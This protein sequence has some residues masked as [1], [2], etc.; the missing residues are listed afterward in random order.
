MDSGAEAKWRYSIDSRKVNRCTHSE[1]GKTGA[2][3]S[4]VQ[5][6]KPCRHTNRTCWWMRP[7]RADKV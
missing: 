5:T 1:E 6:I 7:G 3:Q 4:Q 2:C